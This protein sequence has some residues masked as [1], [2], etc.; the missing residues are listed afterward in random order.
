MEKLIKDSPLWVF[1]LAWLI[2]QV[3]Q[4]TLTPIHYD[5]AYY[6]MYS[7]Q[8]DWGYFDHPPAV[9]FVIWLSNAVFNGL[10]GVR[11]WSIVLQ[12]L[13]FILIWKILPDGKAKQL[14]FVLL[15][16]CLPFFH[17]LGWIT[18]PDVPLLFSAALFFYTY[19]KV[20]DKGKIFD[21]LFWG[22]SMAALIY[23]KYH[24]GLLILIVLISN[25]K[26]FLRPQ[27]YLAGILGLALWSPHI[28]WQFNHDFPTFRYHLQERAGESRWY[29]PL[30]YLGNVLVVINPFLIGF[31]YK[32][33]KRKN[34]NVF[35]R[36]LYF[37]VIGFLGFF[38]F[39]S[40]RDHVQPQWLVLTYFPIIYLLII[41]WDETWN[42]RLLTVFW[43]TLPIILALRIVLMFDLLP[44]DL[45]IH[46]QGEKMGAIKNAAD[47]N[48]VMF[49]NSYKYASLFTWYENQAYTHSYN[50]AYNR[51]NQF[52]IWP[53]DS[54]FH[55][56]KVFL[57]GENYRKLKMKK[58]EDFKGSLHEYASF[59]KLKF[60]ISGPIDFQK[61]KV[62]IDEFNIFNP[63]GHE[64]I[65]DQDQLEIN[66]Q[67][68]NGKKRVGHL[69]A[70][71]VKPQVIFSKQEVI[72]PQVSIP[73][74][75]D[76]FGALMEITHIGFCMENQPWP[77]A[78]IVKKFALP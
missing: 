56:E 45:G 37:V 15:L 33:V 10:L 42:K 6:W 46:R 72:I 73:I 43:V 52:N 69:Q 13:S 53:G 9:A 66:Y 5:E 41:S 23:S 26:L 55:N 64:I 74:P 34:E 16:F 47:T 50:T 48:Q 17:L 39:Q 62:L 29:F 68:F 20:L 25:P 58:Y 12:L 19:K 35:E 49:I 65:V 32:L 28:L 44:A 11:T 2:L 24:G 51:K 75:K 70:L 38:L 59:D 30:E 8:L 77:H 76:E 31:I 27:T 40:F 3:I 36:S 22:I 14:P 78:S 7:Q 1:G 61:E 4:A 71:A 67:F 60:N 18:T 54:I 63:Y 21:Y 57:V